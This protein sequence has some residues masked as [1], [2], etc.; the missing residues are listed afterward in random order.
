MKISHYDRS[1]SDAQRQILTFFAPTIPLENQPKYII[2]LGF[3]NGMFLKQIYNFIC[4]HTLRGKQLKDFPLMLIGVCSNEASLKDTKNTLNDIPHNVVKGDINVPEDLL[5][6]LENLG[7]KDPENILHVYS[8]G[9]N[10]FHYP[11]SLSDGNN[12][13]SS[14]FSLRDIDFFRKSDYLVELIRTWK[15]YLQK[16][17]EILRDNPQSLFILE[18]N[19][20]NLEMTKDVFAESKRLYFDEM[21]IFSEKPFLDSGIFI[22]LAASFRVFNNTQLLTLPHTP[23]FCQITLH[24]LGEIHYQVRHA[25]ID[26]LK[27][28]QNLEKLCWAKEIRMPK[29]VLASRLKDYQEGQFVLQLEGKVVGVIYSQRIRNQDDLHHANSL[30]VSRLHRLD[31]HIVQLLAINIDP[32]VQERRLG[33]QLLE[34]MLQRCEMMPEIHS[35]VGVTRCRDFHKQKNISMA[36]YIHKKNEKGWA[37][38]PILH[39]HELHGASIHVPVSGYR[40]KDT[41]NKGFGVLVHYEIHDRRR[42]DRKY[43]PKNL[44]KEKDNQTKKRFEQALSNQSLSYDKVA[45][46]LEKVIKKLLREDHRKNFSKQ[47]PLM[48]M[49]LDSADILKLSDQISSNLLCDIEPAFFFQ[50]N[51]YERILGYFKEQINVAHIHE[52]EIKLLKEESS[53]PETALESDLKPLRISS[54]KTNSFTNLP[55]NCSDDDLAIVGISCRLPGEINN[56]HELWDFLKDGKSAIGLLPKDR[57]SWPRDIDPKTQ[58]PGIDKGGFIND[59]ASFDASFFRLSPKEMEVIS[60]EQRILLELAWEALDDFGYCAEAVSGSKTGVFIGASGSDYRLLLEQNRVNIEAH[61]STGTSMAV[62]ANR[63]SYFFNFNGP[64]VQI[65]TA[66]SSSLVALHQ[67]VQAL[68]LGECDQVLV[69]GINVICH[70]GNTI[71]YYKAGMLSKDGLCKTFDKNADGYVRSE[72]AVMMVLKPLQQAIADQDLIHAVIKGTAI[73]HGGQASGLTVPNP[74]GQTKLLLEAWKSAGITPDSI[75][76]IEAHGTGT[77]L[78]D[79]IEIRALKE[80]FLAS[81]NKPLHSF[82]KNSC[83]ISSLKSNLG[84]LEAAAGIA[85]LLKVVLCL[86]HQTLVPSINFE[87]INPQINLKESPFYIAQTNQNWSISTPNKVRIACVSSFGSGGTNAHAVLE[88]YRNVIPI[89]TVASGPLLFVLSAKNKDRL[90]AYALKLLNYLDSQDISKSIPSLESFV[91]T[92]QLRQAMDERVAF[93]V[94]NFSDLKEKLRD[95]TQNNPIK[96]G[97]QGNVN[98]SQEIV[99]LFNENAEM[100]QLFNSWLFE[101]GTEKVAKLWVKGISIQNWRRFYKNVPPRMHLPSYPFDRKYYWF[102]E[103]SDKTPILN[104]D[105][106]NEKALDDVRNRELPHKIEEEDAEYIL[107]NSGENWLSLIEEWKYSPLEVDADLW[108]EQI[109]KKTTSDV[110]II[111]EEIND[112]KAI[113]SVFQ[114]IEDLDQSRDNSLNINY[115]KIHSDTEYWIEKSEIEPYLTNSEQPLTIFLFSP[116]RNETI[117]MSREIE[118]LYTFIQSIMKIAVT[119]PIQFYYCYQEQHIEYSL[120]QEGL[121]G[122]FRSLMLENVNHRFRSIAYDAKLVGNSRVILSVIQEWLWDNTTDK[123][124]INVTM[125][126]YIGGDRF[127]LQVF[128]NNKY[129]IVD[130]SPSFK[131]GKTYLM[132]GALGSVGELICQELGRRYQARL[133]IFSRRSK[134]D[135]RE[136]LERIESKGA[137]IVYQPVDILDKI[138]LTKAMESLRKDGIVIHGVIHMAREISEGVFLNKE[139]SEFSSNISAKTEGTLNIDEATRKEPLDFFLIFSSIAAF[140]NRGLSDYAYACAFQNAVSRYRNSLVEQGKC[141]GRSLSICWGPWGIDNAFSIKRIEN[142]RTHWRQNGMDFI[143]I[144]FSIKAIDLSLHSQFSSVGFIAMND[145]Q[146]VLIALGFEQVKSRKEAFICSKIEEFENGTLAEPQFADFLDTLVDEDYTEFIQQRIISS[147]KQAEKMT[148]RDFDWQPIKPIKFKIPVLTST[149]ELVQAEQEKPVTTEIVGQPISEEI[150]AGLEKVLK[151]KKIDFDWN[152]SF[153]DHGLDSISGMQLAT[154]LEKKFNIPI[155]PS[156][157]IEHST[158]NALTV[159]LRNYITLK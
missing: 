111:S 87:E 137:S 29:N 60:P 61:M 26:D 15:T 73:N 32:K 66:C 119:K 144:A 98:E 158:L 20:L 75:S 102:K 125:I 112:Y 101:E 47:S 62:L 4:K 154:V 85:G 46:F 19:S 16:W 65:D 67:A 38:D 81:S 64:S 48:E 89:K 138:A 35:V 146:K 44:D 83:A 30:N 52:N 28:L 133:V 150:L 54:N 134:E 10:H 76:Y 8:C 63:I 107:Q 7:I 90:K 126:R 69:G 14:K 120:Y 142:L 50:Y 71:S 96:G 110:L 151:I 51:S 5:Y 31:G 122:L 70:P 97:Y 127:E 6:E 131:K 58:F 53:L 79:P 95:L 139:F 91:Y 115:I 103:T 84:H 40:S 109:E 33:D 153:Q 141:S 93:F 21:H 37:F 147:I 140:G 82:P 117:L 156:W 80:A 18:A 24:Y 116:K 130:D 78:G 41:Q 74:D 72:G 124:A 68:R 42:K 113:N 2:D 123:S 22:V 88:E 45:A 104:I 11:S 118:F 1:F 43:N 129:K 49:G 128:E 105:F 59:I 92:L 106:C 100:Q 57:W 148:G 23:S 9:N 99:Q 136:I 86:K 145:K 77:K 36:K 155:Q 159:K 135:V 55:K 12:P 39:F 34:F 27:A 25:K 114:K 3:G 17:G 121:V 94:D 132:V 149:D 56:M 157:L 143:D 152:Q 13:L 108:R